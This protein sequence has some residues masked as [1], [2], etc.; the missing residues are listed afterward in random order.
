MSYRATGF[1]PDEEK[2]LLAAARGEAAEEKK[3]DEI[4]AFTR[5]QDQIRVVMT[6]GI[7]AG[8]IF[9]LTRLGDLVHT[10]RTRG[11]ES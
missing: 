3:V 6:V 8:L 2:E 9:T 7:V 10:M 11:R 1:T 4:L 5:K